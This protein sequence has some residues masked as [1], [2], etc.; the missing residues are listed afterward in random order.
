MRE[1]AMCLL[2][3]CLLVLGDLCM[4]Q[5][6]KPSVSKF[7]AAYLTYL[8]GADLEV[9]QVYLSPATPTTEDNIVFTAVIRNRGAIR[10]PA[11]VVCIRVG[12][13]TFGKLYPI[14]ALDPGRSRV[15][16]RY[17]RLS[18]AQYY[19]VTAIA[20]AKKQVR[21]SNERNNLKYKNFQVVPPR[22]LQVTY[23]N[24]PNLGPFKIV[25][26]KVRMT[27]V[28]NKPVRKSSVI[29][30]SNFRV[31]FRYDSNAAGTITWLSPR[32]IKWT[33]VK[34]ES[35]LNPSRDSFWTLTMYDSIT[36]TFGGRLDGD[37]NGVAGGTCTISYTFVK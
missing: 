32:A 27:I 6:V 5:L 33:S 7:N 1:K 24:R 37:K 18:K 3:V 8:R 29:P 20:D 35:A 25:N 17:Q 9:S 26:G 36:D 12:G 11:S 21:E 28:F 30:R 10:A 13:E 31:K 16:R 23:P 14:P 19:R 22:P 2:V 15:V 4:A 34:N